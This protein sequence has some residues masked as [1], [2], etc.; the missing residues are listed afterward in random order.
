LASPLLQGR[1]RLIHG[2]LREG[3]VV[4]SIRGSRRAGGAAAASNGLSVDGS[5]LQEEED[6]V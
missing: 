3:A 4:V 5:T 2:G 6:T 1:P